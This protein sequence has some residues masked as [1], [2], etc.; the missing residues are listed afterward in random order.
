MQHAPLFVRGSSSTSKVHNHRRERAEVERLQS[1]ISK[2]RRLI[3]VAHAT[4]PDKRAKIG[5]GSL[6]RKAALNQEPDLQSA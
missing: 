6:R 4:E 5:T 1:I 2:I 3:S